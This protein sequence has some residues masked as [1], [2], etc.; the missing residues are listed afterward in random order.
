MVKYSILLFILAIFSTSCGGNSS[1]G[2][3]VSHDANVAG[4]WKIVL[5]ENQSAAFQN[6]GDTND[7][8]IAIGFNQSGPALLP[9]SNQDVWTGNIGCGSVGQSGWWWIN[10]AWNPTPTGG[11]QR[12]SLDSG[13]VVTANT[14]AFVFT[15]TGG[16]TTATGKLTFTGTVHADGSMSG[17]LIDGCILTNGVPT[18]NITWNATRMASF[19]PTSWP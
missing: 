18:S 8:R 19:P 5:G 9:L 4:N 13:G 11:S 3:N 12:I 6:G 2:G 16:P 7:S 14:V 15:E 10:G 17:T 1:N